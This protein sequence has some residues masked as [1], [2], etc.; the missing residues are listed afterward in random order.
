LDTVTSIHIR[1]WQNSE[2]DVS[3]YKDHIDHFNFMISWI[4]VA[5]FLDLD[6]FPTIVY[7][8]LSKRTSGCY[9]PKHPLKQHVE[10][11]YL[12]ETKNLR[13]T[14]YVVVNFANLVLFHDTILH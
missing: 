4:G 1:Q 8:L 10:Y 3:Y 13:Q 7:I 5:Y 11:E 6:L 14:K 9:M 2:F 12:V